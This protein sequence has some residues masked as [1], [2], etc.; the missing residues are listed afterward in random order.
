LVYSFVC[1]ALGCCAK[2]LV[3]A[4]VWNTW[5]SPTAPRSQISRCRGWPSLFSSRQLL[6][7]PHTRPP[8]PTQLVNPARPVRPRT[9]TTLLMLTRPEPLPGGRGLVREGEEALSVVEGVVKGAGS[10]LLDWS[11][12]FCLVATRSQTRDWGKRKVWSPAPPILDF[13]LCLVAT[14]GIL[15]WLELCPYFTSTTCV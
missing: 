13:K 15:L 9:I 14:Y 8:S 7:T 12:W 5:I 11:V 1:C 10:R 4:G 6:H 3:V 2:L